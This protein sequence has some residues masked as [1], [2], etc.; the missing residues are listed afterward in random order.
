MG[1][2]RRSSLRIRGGGTNLPVEQ[3]SE[4]LRLGISCNGADAAPQEGE[5]DLNHMMCRSEGSWL[6]SLLTSTNTFLHLVHL[7]E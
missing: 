5:P 3:R 2:G 1:G 7:Y 6:A 4:A